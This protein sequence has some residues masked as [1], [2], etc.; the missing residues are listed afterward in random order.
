MAIVLHPTHQYAETRFFSDLSRTLPYHQ[1]DFAACGSRRQIALIYEMSIDLIDRHLIN[2][3]HYGRPCTLTPDTIAAGRKPAGSTNSRPAC[4]H[5]RNYHGRAAP[6]A[7]THMANKAK[8]TRSKL[9]RRRGRRSLGRRLS[10]DRMPNN[11]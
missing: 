8:F 11:N 10:D 3:Q 5:R 4:R 2:L 1:T 9:F 6:G 7:P